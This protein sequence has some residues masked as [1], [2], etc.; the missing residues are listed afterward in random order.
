[1]LYNEI[2]CILESDFVLSLEVW[3]VISHMSTGREFGSH[4]GY[5][6]RIGILGSKK[7]TVGRIPYPFTLYYY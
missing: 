7:R 6:G 1:V 4:T 3:V 5:E 2:Q